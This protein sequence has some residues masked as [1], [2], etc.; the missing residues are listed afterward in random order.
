MNVTV[1]AQALSSANEKVKVT[2]IVQT[3]NVSLE[4]IAK[5]YHEQVSDESESYNYL[6]KEKCI[7]L[8]LSKSQA[9]KL[10]NMDEVDFLERDLKVQGSSENKVMASECE[11]EWNIN[12]PEIMWKGKI[13][14][15][16]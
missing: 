6:E 4:K 11:D 5:K 2:Y 13:Y 9:A 10:E 15:Y 7:L 1:S 3:K 14:R 8:D 12:I 16:Q